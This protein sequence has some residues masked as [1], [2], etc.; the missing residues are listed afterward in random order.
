MNDINFPKSI[1]ERYDAFCR[2]A[3]ELLSEAGLSTPEQT[4]TITGRSFYEACNSLAALHFPDDKEV[5]GLGPR[6]LIWDMHSA[7]HGPSIKHNDPDPVSSARAVAAVVRNVIRHRPPLDLTEKPGWRQ[8]PA[9]GN[10]QKST[11]AQSAELTDEQLCF[12]IMSFSRNPVLEDF[13][14]KAIKPTVENLGYRCERV[15]EQ[16]FNDSIRARI[17][18]N[19]RKAKFI[20]AD[21]T[22]AR[23]NCYYEIG[24][25]H[26]IEKNVIHLANATCDI[27]FDV[28]DFNFIVYSRIDER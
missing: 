2:D 17:L 19:I 11:I 3:Q 23:P 10:E 15:D 14:V 8:R 28:K 27:H 1:Q 6:G 12:V 18:S 13:Y 20:V 25:A 5:G 9:A 22:E 7:V 21:V 24:V 4:P 26:S 16:E